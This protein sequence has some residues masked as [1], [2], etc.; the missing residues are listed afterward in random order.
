MQ[1]PHNLEEMLSIHAIRKN[2][3]ND[4]AD[5]I[6]LKVNR[7]HVQPYA[8]CLLQGSLSVKGLYDTGAD[9]TC[10]SLATFRKIPVDQRPQKD[11]SVKNKKIQ[12]AN[13]DVV[14]TL[15]TY[16][17]DIKVQG[18]TVKHPCK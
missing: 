6:E 7:M 16:H 4:F 18:K 2:I 3:C 11:L 10:M 1:V 13:D 12:V 5:Q 14:A 8:H 15:G 9:I 17:L